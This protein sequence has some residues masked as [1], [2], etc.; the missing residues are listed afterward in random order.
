VWAALIGLLGTLLLLLWTATEH[1]A[2]YRNMNLFHYQPLWLAMALALTVASAQWRRGRSA[3]AA[4]FVRAGAM[5][6]AVASVVGFV[7]LAFPSLR[8]G[9][10]APVALAAPLN[11]AAAFALVRLFPRTHPTST[12]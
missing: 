12:K 2:A 3:G 9:F 5:V 8:Q 4:A 1:Q 10:G 11:L 6:S 7:V